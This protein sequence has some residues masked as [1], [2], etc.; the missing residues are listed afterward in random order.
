MRT[1]TWLRRRHPL[2]WMIVLTG[3]VYLIYRWLPT[4]AEHQADLVLTVVLALAFGWAVVLMVRR[5]R[6]WTWRG[7]G[8]LG[9]VLGDALLYTALGVGATLAYRAVLIDLARACLTVGVVH[10]LIGLIGSTR[11]ADETEPGIVEDVEPSAPPDRREP[12]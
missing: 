11:E 7:Q 8:L 10:L 3:V 1:V 12:A 4:G 9:T 6:T 2:L 5:T